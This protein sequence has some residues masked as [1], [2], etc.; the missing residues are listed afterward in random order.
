MKR[1]LLAF[2]VVAVASGCWAT[3][4][5]VDGPGDG[6][7]DSVDDFDDIALAITNGLV[8]PNLDGDGAPD[9]I[10]VVVDSLAMTNAIN[11]NG[12]TTPGH[13]DDITIN[14]DADGNGTV[15][16]IT[17]TTPT[18]GVIISAV[19]WNLDLAPNQDVVIRDF[20]NIPVDQ[21]VVAAATQNAG[22]LVV[23]EANG[24][25]N[26]NATVLLERFSYT[27]STAGNVAVNPDAAAPADVTRWRDVSG[28]GAN[29][30]F[31][32]S[33]GG[34]GK[35]ITMRDCTFAHGAQDQVW[36]YIDDGTVATMTRC[37]V[38]RGVAG[39]VIDGLGAT[40]AGSLVLNLTD[41]EFAFHDNH[42][43]NGVDGIAAGR[44]NVTVGPGCVFQNNAFR[45]FEQTV[46]DGNISFAGSE[47]KPVIVRNNGN[48]GIRF[49]NASAALGASSWL[50]V[51]SNSV[52][53]IELPAIDLN[54]VSPSFTRCLFA[55]NGDTLT[56]FAQFR[57]ADANTAAAT[58]TF[59]DC[60]FH[61]VGRTAA[62]K[63]DVATTHAHMLVANTATDL[64]TFNFNRCIFSDET[65]NDDF[66]FVTTAGDNNTMNFTNNG[67]PS[68]GPFRVGST[69]GT[70][71]STGGVGNVFNQTGT[72]ASN[73]AYTTT[74]VT[75]YR[76][77]HVTGSSASGYNDAGGIN[78][79]GYGKFVPVLNLSGLSFTTDGN[80]AEWLADVAPVGT[81]PR[82]FRILGAQQAIYNDTIGDNTG[83]GDFVSPT[84]GAFSN[85]GVDI[86]EVRVAT[87]GSNLRF[88]V[89]TNGSSP[90]GFGPNF[91]TQGCVVALSYNASGT[92]QFVFQDG[93]MT[94]TTDLT[95]DSSLILNETASGLQLA[96]NTSG[97][98]GAQDE[99]NSAFEF[100]LPYSALPIGIDTFDVIVG[101]GH[102]AG[103]NFRKVN[104][105]AAGAFEGGNGAS[106]VR[107]AD[108]DNPR[109]YDLAGAET[110]AGQSDDYINTEGPAGF[111]MIRSSFLTF[112]LQV[113]VPVEMTKFLVD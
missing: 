80:P 36:F 28:N 98:S 41:C 100:T 90:T 23:D 25:A 35:T 53:G 11:V 49:N 45:G 61:D 71:D 85:S 74:T 102:A 62:V 56:P 113:P 21:P 107:A 95:H 20:R 13:T 88:L 1:W 72:I 105:G 57:V 67:F 40:D 101:L 34:A 24:A 17:W 91:E 27:A 42:G 94:M 64:V 29:L 110:A 103:S 14:G 86:K 65:N 30:A 109:L 99:A 54:L 8:T 93:K 78:V 50:Q 51:Y 46:P 63:N 33:P 44:A 68:V 38:L 47:R 4:L 75:N 69:S 83:D 79:S 48:R 52:Y 76:A 82:D 87:D 70:L 89:T 3:T 10:N 39:S 2:L 66:V 9:V 5:K 37:R 6:D 73:P 112:K 106:A 22:V 97:A 104:D 58:I 84:D 32:S 31:Q 96:G 81:G 108:N 77:F 18:G 26:A 16:T 92:N 15:C 19:A 7:G 43:V 60:T 55:N 111:P 59:N 12:N